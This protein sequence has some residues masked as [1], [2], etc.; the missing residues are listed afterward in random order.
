[1][2]RMRNPL[3]NLAP[4]AYRTGKDWAEYVHV[5]VPKQLYSKR[6]WRQ[7]VAI[8]QALV[9]LF[10]IAAIFW[11][12]SQFGWELNTV[13]AWLVFV[14]AIGMFLPISD[15]LHMS[16]IVWIQNVF[17]AMIVTAIGLG[18]EQFALGTLVIFG[19]LASWS[20]VTTLG[21]LRESARFEDT[22]DEGYADRHDRLLN[23]LERA[24][25]P[26]GKRAARRGAEP[27]SASLGSAGIVVTSDAPDIDGSEFEL[28]K[29]DE[30][31]DDSDVVD[32]VIVDENDEVL[33]AEVAGPEVMVV[34]GSAIVV[35]EA[36]SDE[37]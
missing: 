14:T 24:T 4:S 35:G 34:G 18:G 36:V 21:M 32:A 13:A 16:W 27:E 2:T 9:F 33:V 11:A 17:G 12:V 28:S 29:P 30:D 25:R 7:R 23:E 1:M 19:L 37:D 10:E 15:S 26:L 20:G 3:A 22:Y 6:G 8:R 5:K 31:E